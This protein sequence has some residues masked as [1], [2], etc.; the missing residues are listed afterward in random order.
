MAG[1]STVTQPG[2]FPKV[3]L[4][5]P[6]P[7]KVLAGGCCLTL[8]PPLACR[9]S[10]HRTT[11]GTTHSSSAHPCPPPCTPSLG[12]AAPS[13]TSAAHPVTSTSRP[14]TTVP[15]PVAP[16]TAKGAR[17]ECGVGVPLAGQ[18]VGGLRQLPASELGLSSAAYEARL[19]PLHRQ[20]MEAPGD[21][22]V[23]ER[24]HNQ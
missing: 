9:R 19:V 12:P 15:R 5:P 17:G 3:H 6:H 2:F 11:P 18:P 7:Q 10:S 24:I 1:R 13:W 21:G 4:A 20:E 8:G 23:T 14:R 22:E 16:P